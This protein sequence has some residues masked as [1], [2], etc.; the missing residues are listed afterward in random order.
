MGSTQERWPRIRRRLWLWGR[1]GYYWL[2][3]D[4]DGTPSVPAGEKPWRALWDYGPTE[5]VKDAYCLLGDWFE[6]A[7]VARKVYA[8]A[9]TYQRQR[10]GMDIRQAIGMV[11]APDDLKFRALQYSQ[12]PA[13]PERRQF[14]AE[15]PEM[16]EFFPP[17][18]GEGIPM[19]TAAAR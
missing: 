13:N 9:I 17:I 11:D 4:A 7:G 15:H 14:R 12:L 19:E 5:M 6:A 8:Q 3:V 2:N 18:G 1:G 16:F 10:P